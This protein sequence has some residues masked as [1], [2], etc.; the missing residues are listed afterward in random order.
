MT[1]EDLKIKLT[2]LKERNNQLYQENVQP[3]IK[4]KVQAF[5]HAF[6]EYFRER[7]F[8]V[9]KDQHT[10]K[11]AY[12]SLEFTAFTNDSHDIFI[13]KEREQIASISVKHKNAR[14]DSQVKFAD[15]LEK[16]SKEIDIEKALSH[17]LENPTLYYTGSEYGHQYDTPLS[18]LESIFHA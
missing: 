7:G 1:I 14:I 3:G 11:V 12:D 4:I 17:D 16:L 15:P 6:E 2:N 8:V 18:V 9:K 10:V 5:L 13:M